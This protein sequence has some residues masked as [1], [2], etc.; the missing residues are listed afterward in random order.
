MASLENSYKFGHQMPQL[1]LV[2]NW[3]TRWLHLHYFQIWPPDG[4][5]CISYKFG[6]QM[7]PLALVP[8]LATSCRHLSHLH[9]HIALDCPIGIINQY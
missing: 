1:A 7:A 6:Y 5:T 9:C 8:N 2:P 3:A 4:A